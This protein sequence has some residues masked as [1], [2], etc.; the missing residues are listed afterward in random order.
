MPSMIDKQK[1]LS[2][3]EIRKAFAPR[4]LGADQAHST[5]DAPNTVTTD[6]PNIVR[7]V[8]RKGLEGS[9]DGADGSG[10]KAKD[11]LVDEERGIIGSQG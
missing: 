6:E 11:V 3:D 7:V 4:K 8:K 9:A 1:G 5:P 10:P 2:A